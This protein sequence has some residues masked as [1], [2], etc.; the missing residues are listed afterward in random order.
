MPL[1]AG[2]NAP[3]NKIH[4]MQKIP[5]ASFANTNHFKLVRDGEQPIPHAQLEVHSVRNE[6][7]LVD[8]AVSEIQTD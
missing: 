7:G 3:S 2:R 1:T 4:A 5:K 8:W 6:K